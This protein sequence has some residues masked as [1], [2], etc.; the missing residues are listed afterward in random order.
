[1]HWLQKNKHNLTS[2]IFIMFIVFLI[3]FVTLILIN[4]FKGYT[5]PQSVTGEWWS[6]L[7]IVV[8][9]SLGILV[10]NF[11]RESDYSDFRKNIVSYEERITNTTEL[12]TLST[13]L[14]DL[15]SEE[16]TNK[17]KWSKNLKKIKR[18]YKLGFITDDDLNKISLVAW[19]Q[20]E[21][22]TS[23]Q[24]RYYAYK[25]NPNNL[26]L[27]LYVISI[28]PF[29][30]SKDREL[31]NEQIKS[32]LERKNLLLNKLKFDYNKD[33]LLGQKFNTDKF[34]KFY[35][36]TFLDE[37]FAYA[38]VARIFFKEGLYEECI[39]LF[40]KAEIINSSNGQPFKRWYYQYILISYLALGRF[41]EFERI[42]NAKKL[43][44]SWFEDYR[45]LGL[46]NLFARL[47]DLKNGKLYT[48][49][50]KSIYLK[51]FAEGKR[52]TSWDFGKIIEKAFE[53]DTNL[54]G[55]K[56]TDALNIQKR[57]IE[58]YRD[59]YVVFGKRDIQFEKDN[60]INLNY[61]CYEFIKGILK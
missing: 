55:V 47:I 54:K 16:N 35:K 44:T 6:A 40:K 4:F 34:I 30:E 43:E 10:L 57:A 11:I 39:E 8:T 56:K 29:I 28:Y 7:G 32:I 14:L 50:D 13:I 5:F 37:A 23:F 58:Y 60:N 42:F 27:F 25:K 48:P 46:L 31:I 21:I 15:T 49:V 2:I 36:P 53:V 26:I 52:L 22:F 38:V 18:L 19:N 1:M 9:L 41:D 17:Q 12:A 20:G 59:Y 24:M 51:A 45:Y 33:K 3:I 61:H